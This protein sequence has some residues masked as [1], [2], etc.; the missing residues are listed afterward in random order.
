MK[1][2]FFLLFFLF[3]SFVF[4]QKIPCNQ[5]KTGE[6][7]YSNPNYSEWEITRNDSIQI[8]TSIKT[9]MK[10]YSFIV[11]KSE[12]EY[13]LTCFKVLNTTKKNIVGKVFIV[14]IFETYN[15]KYQCISKSTD[16]R[17]KDI[18]LEMIKTN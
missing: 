13:V 4:C 3:T 10:I 1:K 2:L 18:E 8:E 15:D 6:F 16:S 14:T 12:C 9:G 7:K 17:I 5:F 11:W